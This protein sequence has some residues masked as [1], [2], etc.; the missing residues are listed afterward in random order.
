M[1]KQKQHQ[2][3]DEKEPAKQLGDG[4]TAPKF[5]GLIKLPTTVR[6]RWLTAGAAVVLFLVVLAATP[7]SRYGISGQLI[8]K[9]VKVDVSD[10]RTGKPVSDVSVTIGPVTAKTNAE[11]EATLDKVPVGDWLLLAGKKYY[12]PDLEHINVPLLTNP[13]T[14]KLKIVAL[15]NQVTIKVLNK[16][17]NKPIA[18]AGI[19]ALGTTTTTDSSGE[20][21]LVLPVS[22]KTASGTLSAPGYNKESVQIANTTST[23]DV[24]YDAPT[25]KV[26]YLSNASGKIDVMGSN[27]DGTDPQVIVAGTGN[28]NT[29]DTQ[30]LSTTD[31]KYL[32]LLSRRDSATGN[33]SVY[34]V[35]TSTGALSTIDQG[36]AS[37]QLVGWYDHTFV[38]SVDRY[39]GNYGSNAP[40]EEL[41]KSYNAATGKL[42]T[43]YQTSA[44]GGCPSSDINA[45]TFYNGYVT[46]LVNWYGGCQ[47]QTQILRVYPDGSGSGVVKSASGGSSIDGLVLESPTK[48]DYSF[49]SGLGSTETY[50]QI[51]S[52][53]TKQVGSI[54]NQYVTGSQIT[55]IYSPSWKK[56][57]WYELRD[58][59][60]S[61]FIGD[62]NGENGVQVD[63]LS[64]YTPYGWY[65]D[66]YVLF[67]DKNGQ[68][69]IG[70]ADF[71]APPTKISDYYSSKQYISGYGSGY[72]G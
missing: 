17:T 64:Q 5:L 53:G 72:G 70:P 24:F 13:K 59:N 46:F 16:L 52:S 30:L 1:E 68:L 35:D 58:G 10:S 6:D 22:S 8:K 54:P 26:Y 71:S 3:E 21:T 51:T 42:T 45:T 12:T 34:L 2:I 36:N 27:L 67:T 9:T 19:N 38:Y 66:N 57:F 69:F 15:G 29:Q 65:T 28:E 40:G 41:I 33:P 4:K 39:T 37:F 61:L 23:P 18:K 62:E 60:N 11:G 49:S 44:A 20:A 7:Y 56:T 43:I 25:G 55:Y 50:Y 31:W 47:G 32:A 48:L 14:A 63:P